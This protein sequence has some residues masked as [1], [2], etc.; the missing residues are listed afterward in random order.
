MPAFGAS[1]VPRDNEPRRRNQ[2][3]RA[4]SIPGQRGLGFRNQ[5]RRPRPGSLQP[6][7]R[8]EGGL[9]RLGVLADPLAGA[10]LVAGP[11]KDVIGLSL[12]PI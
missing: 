9:A 8:D 2:V 10:D 5:R 3:G 4:F 1:F 7:K 12:I 6:Q 11:I